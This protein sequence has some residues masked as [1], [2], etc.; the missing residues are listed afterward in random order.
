MKSI[1]ANNIQIA[2]QDEG[3]GPPLLLLH[4]FSLDHSMWAAQVENLQRSYRLIVPDQRGSGETENPSEAFSIETMADDAAA[5]LE[6]LGI[7]A[8]AVAGFSMGGYILAQMLVRHPLKVRAAAFVSTGGTNA[9]S[10]ERQEARVKTMRFVVDEGTSAFADSYIPQLFSPTYLK[11]HPLEVAKTRGVIEGQRPGS[12]ALLLGALRERQDV[13]Y[14]AKN[15]G[16]PCAAIGGREDV[17]VPPD[18]VEGLHEILPDSTIEL[19]DGAGHLSTVEAPGTV[20]D[21]LDRLMQRAGMW[22]V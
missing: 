16:V 7:S 4:G 3:N 9:D 19:I 14:H 17:L 11:S 8:A 10:P 1:R 5:V 22:E 12:I 15:F 18:V 20:S 2:Y 13:S 6:A 21:Q